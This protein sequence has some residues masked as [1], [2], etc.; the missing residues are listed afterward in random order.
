[1]LG[2]DMDS[3]MVDAVHNT[4]VDTPYTIPKPCVADQGFA[5]KR[6]ST[7]VYSIPDSTKKPRASN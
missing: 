2:K 1:M 3:T 5:G 4:A 7:T 6:S